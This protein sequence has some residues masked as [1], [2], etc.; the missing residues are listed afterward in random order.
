M[1]SAPG[2]R[3]G[4]KTTEQWRSRGEDI[5]N[6]ERSNR[7][8]ASWWWLWLSMTHLITASKETP[9]M[10]QR[11]S[12]LRRWWWWRWDNSLCCPGEVCWTLCVAARVSSLRASYR[13]PPGAAP[14]G[15]DVNQTSAAI[16]L[17]YNVSFL[18]R[19]GSPVRHCIHLLQL[20]NLCQWICQRTSKWKG[21]IRRKKKMDPWRIRGRA[22]PRLMGPWRGLIVGPS[23]RPP[24]EA[25]NQLCGFSST[26]QLEPV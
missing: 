13:R 4:V 21:W 25:E 12:T 7:Q 17:K 19:G 16:L 9:P 20:A 18:R 22:S 15:R 14:A 23:G 11:L 6:V 24:S 8:N 3:G 1:A 5:R 2:R 26:D 10:D